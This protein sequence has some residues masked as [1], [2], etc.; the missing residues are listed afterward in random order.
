M[1]TIE[2]KMLEA[3][4]NKTDWQLDNT[5]VK[6]DAQTDT[7]RVHLF[8]NHICSYPHRKDKAPRVNKTVFAKYPTRTTVSRLR[9]L[10]I[11]A[12]VKNKQPTI[13]GVAI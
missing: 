5:S 2:T 13:N 11:D 3:I 8:Y 10:G 7:S 1:R 12:R 6:Y 4:I 9:A